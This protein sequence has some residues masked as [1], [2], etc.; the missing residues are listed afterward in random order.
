MYRRLVW[1]ILPR[2]G[3]AG[4]FAWRPERGAVAYPEGTP[5]PP[6][7]GRPDQVR[8]AMTPALR[9]IAPVRGWAR[10]TAAQGRRGVARV[11]A[12]VARAIQA[13]TRAWHALASLVPAPRRAPAEP[14]APAPEAQEAH[15]AQGAQGA[16]GAGGA[17]TPQAPANGG[18]GASAQGQSSTPAQGPATRPVL[19]PLTADQRTRI[20]NNL[21]LARALERYAF[22]SGP[23]GLRRFRNVWLPDRVVIATPGVSG[24]YASREEMEADMRR[25][26]IIGLALAEPRAWQYTGPAVILW[27]HFLRTP[28]RRFTA[29]QQDWVQAT[30]SPILDALAPIIYAIER[31]GVERRWAMGIAL[32]MARTVSEFQPWQRRA[33]VDLES[34]IMSAQ[35]LSRIRASHRFFDQ[36]TMRRHLAAT[37]NLEVVPGVDDQGNTVMIRRAVAWQTGYYQGGAMGPRLFR[38]VPIGL[39]DQPMVRV[40]ELVDGWGVPIARASGAPAPTAGT[41]PQGSAATAPSPGDTAT[42]PSTGEAATPPSTEGPQAG[43]VAASRGAEG[44]A[45]GAADGSPRPHR[46]RGRGPAAT[47]PAASPAP[48]AP[49]TGT[50]GTAGTDGTSRGRGTDAAPQGAAPEDAGGEGTHEGGTP[51]AGSGTR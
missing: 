16:Q 21:A 48:E 26:H 35:Y 15:E 6:I 8:L 24:R 39:D 47:P 7:L 27:P 42:S 50:A 46:A 23:D 18:A 28:W 40:G 1:A 25:R 29:A 17:P 3:W 34:Y 32:L 22:G 33:G 12:A 4:A 13:L 37:G 30:V 41:A 36:E 11:A 38:G 45:G 44:P 10:R 14:E 51:P 43:P 2:L 5:I 20:Q 31:N 49:E 19:R 9:V